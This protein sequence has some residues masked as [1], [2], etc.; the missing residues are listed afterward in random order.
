MSCFEHS[1]GCFRR[2]FAFLFSSNPSFVKP[3]TDLKILPGLTLNAFSLSLWPVPG[4]ALTL[5]RL[6]PRLVFQAPDIS[7]VPARTRYKALD[8]TAAM[9]ALRLTVTACFRRTAAWQTGRR[10]QVAGRRGRREGRRGRRPSRRAG[11][12]ATAR[13]G[14]LERW[15]EEPHDFR[16][17]RIFGDD[18]ITQQ[19]LKC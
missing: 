11:D 1:F 9:S 16:R 19:Q 8:S 6:V 18:S 12:P 4:M 15:P 2:R 10:G 17:L 14:R 7:S 13:S 3:V 5:N